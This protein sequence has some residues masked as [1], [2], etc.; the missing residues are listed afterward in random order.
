MSYKR[1]WMEK[2]NPNFRSTAYRFDNT[3]YLMEYTL[4][5]FAQFVQF[6][7]YGIDVDEFNGNL[8]NNENWLP[9]FIENNIAAYYDLETCQ[10]YS[11]KKFFYCNWISLIRYS[12]NFVILFLHQN[13]I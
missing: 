6:N 10:N 9:T 13:M 11:K 12:I 1:E 3:L 7:H 8:S 4:I 2:V 5:I